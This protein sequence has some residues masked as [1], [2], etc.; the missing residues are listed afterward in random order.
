MS[1]TSMLFSPLQFIAMVF[2]VA[3]NVHVLAS[4]CAY[5]DKIVYASAYIRFACYNT[6]RQA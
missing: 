1:C 2:W 4:R 5:M 6:V 3:A